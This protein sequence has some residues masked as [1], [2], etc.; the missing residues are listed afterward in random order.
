MFL[1]F[2]ATI[3]ALIET[4]EEFHAPRKLRCQVES[5]FLK[6]LRGR[7]KTFNGMQEETIMK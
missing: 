6:L 7:V 4:K 5:L 2:K 1:D 3:T